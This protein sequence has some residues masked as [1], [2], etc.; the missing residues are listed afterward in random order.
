MRKALVSVIAA[1]L[2]A[3]PVQARDPAI[4][5]GPGA[6][7][8]GQFK[9]QFGGRTTAKPQA[10]LAIAPTRGSVS[11]EGMVRTKIGEGLALNLVGSKPT[12]T[13]AGTRADY[14]LGLQRDRQI[15]TDQKLGI[16]T[17]AWVAIGLGTA[18]IVGGAIWYNAVTDC[19][20]NDDECG[21]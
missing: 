3:S 5:L 6:F 7:V 9:M 18:L 4:D 10:G 16:S 2:V 14:A 1:C 11:S 13:L 12:L 20:D 21:F 8:G 15:D 17:G 19:D